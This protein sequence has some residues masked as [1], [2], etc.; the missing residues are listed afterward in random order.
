MC[1]RDRPEWACDSTGHSWT[2][3]L[4]TSG[5]GTVAYGADKQC[6]NS[7][8]TKSY[9][10]NGALLKTGVTSGYTV[11]GSKMGWMANNQLLA[12]LAPYMEVKYD[13]VSYTHLASIS[14]TPGCSHTGLKVIEPKSC[15]RNAAKS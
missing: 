11:N 9:S 14:A 4:N 6:Y 7:H 1:I 15:L 5:V 3:G 10:G 2:F 13:A 8:I 12:A